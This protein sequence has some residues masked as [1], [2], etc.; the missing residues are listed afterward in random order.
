[1][2]LQEEER[3]RCLC[4]GH[5]S[6]VACNLRQPGIPR[7]EWAGHGNCEAAGSFRCS[8]PLGQGPAVVEGGPHAPHRI[9]QGP[10]VSC[11]ILPLDPKKNHC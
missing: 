10:Q 11:A 6:A 1:M 9:Q 8:D 5:D 4:L 3:H 2:C 7:S